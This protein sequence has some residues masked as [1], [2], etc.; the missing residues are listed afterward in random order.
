MISPD[1]PRD[2][3]PV[4][5][6]R[7]R[8]KTL[9]EPFIGQ[10]DATALGLFGKVVAAV[11]TLLP[12]D[13]EDVA[14][15]RAKVEAQLCLDGIVAKV[16]NRDLIEADAVGE[17]FVAVQMQRAT[18]QGNTGGQLH[19]GI[20]QVDCHHDVVFA[21]D[22]AEQEGLVSLN[23]K[24]KAGEITRLLMEQALLAQSDG[25]DV[26]IAIEDGEGV[27]VQKHKGA[28]VGERGL[29]MDI[30]LIFDLNYI[31]PYVGP[32]HVSHFATGRLCCRGAEFAF[33]QVGFTV[34]DALVDA[35]I[36]VTHTACTEPLFEDAANGAAVESVDASNCFCG[37][38]HVV[39]DIAGDSVVD[40][41]GDGTHAVG[42]DGSAARHGFGKDEA[43]G[44]LPIDQEHERGGIAEKL[45]LLVLADFADV[46]YERMIEEALD[47]GVEVVLVNLVDFCGYL[48]RHAGAFCDFDGA[49]YSFFRGD[50]ADECE[51]FSFGVGGGIKLFGQS[52]VHGADPVRPL[53]GLSL[54]V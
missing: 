15:V 17:K 3:V 13:F 40:Y 46:L 9:I 41:L 36:V 29:R 6:M 7:V 42:D 4:H 1:A 18:R 11:L 14:E 20:G 27:V 16:M 22:G 53:H 43:E 54:G 30:K 5:W 32:G 10:Y 35:D 21:D 25:L 37:V 34:A 48:E 26:T 24:L 31:S 8:R 44:L 19:I 51:V 52:M 28:G 2:D 50:A 49:I 12:A 38:I 23:Q 47:L 39:N 33:R 45:C